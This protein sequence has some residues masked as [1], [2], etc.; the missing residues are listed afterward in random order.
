MDSIR[1]PTRPGLIVIAPMLLAIGDVSLA[2]EEGVTVWVTNPR[3]RVEIALGTHSWP[4]LADLEVARDGSFDEVGFNMN[5]AAHLPMRRFGRSE[6]LAGI[7]IGL[8]SNESDIRFTSDTLIARNGYITPSIKWMF[9]SGHRYSLDAGLGYYMQDVAEVV[10]E[11]PAYWET[12]LWEEG[13]VGGYIGGT[14]DFGSS[15]PE[16]NHGVMLSCKIHFV[17]FGRVQDEAEFVT[18]TLGRDAGDLSGPIYT[19]QL[20]YRWR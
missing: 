4:G 18:A 1:K 11:Y 10:G 7:D 3:P 15:K 6:L 20:G 8:I 19:M 14:F 16:K 12:Q 5:L 17:E 9:G 2:E 13:S